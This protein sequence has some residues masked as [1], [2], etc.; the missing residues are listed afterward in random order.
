MRYEM[1]AVWIWASVLTVA[2]EFIAFLSQTER[3]P[4]K[5]TKAEKEEDN[6][7]D[8]SC[9]AKVYTYICVAPL[10]AF[11]TLNFE[12]FKVCRDLW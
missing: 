6:A 5:T 4:A 3:N 7:D 11:R 12:G 10:L 1:T 9:I 8:P 2:Q